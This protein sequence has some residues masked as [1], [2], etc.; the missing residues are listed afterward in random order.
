MKAKA[1]APD[2]D[3]E[4]LFDKYWPMVLMR[5]RQ[6]LGDDAGAEDAAQEVFL[7]VLEKRDSLNAE[8]PSSLLWTMATNRCLNVL[9]SRAQR[10]EKPDGNSL[11]ERVASPLNIEAAIGARTVLRKLFERHLESS[12]TIAVLYLIDGMT[13]EEVALAVGMSVAGVHKR[14]RAL[15]KDLRE[16]ED[17]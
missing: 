11:L 1:D 10:G 8:Y 14:L 16:L 9:R 6:M 13:L 17:I 3:A 15:R 12:R 4:K 2:V 5:C 7:K